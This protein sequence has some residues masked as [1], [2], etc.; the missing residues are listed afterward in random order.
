M[1]AAPVRQHRSSYQP[2]RD[3]EVLRVTFAAVALAVP[4]DSRTMMVRLRNATS[5]ARRASLRMPAMPSNTLRSSAASAGF[6]ERVVE[7]QLEFGNRLGLI[8]RN[9][10]TSVGQRD[11]MDTGAPLERSRRPNGDNRALPEDDEF[12]RLVAH[13][14]GCVSWR[15]ARRRGWG[16]DRWWQALPARFPARST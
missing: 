5:T 3:R 6:V 13:W 10:R 7:H 11:Q 9:Q 2:V 14:C 4:F 1:T 8:E 16:R 12:G 15:V